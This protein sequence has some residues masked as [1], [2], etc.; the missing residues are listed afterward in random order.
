MNP[1]IMFT[2]FVS[3]IEIFL[4]ESVSGA[5]DMVDAVYW[6]GYRP[7]PSGKEDYF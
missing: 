1:I 5:G 6:R 7:V 2:E 4:R 3:E